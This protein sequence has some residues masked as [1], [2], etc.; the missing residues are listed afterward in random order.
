MVGVGAG[1]SLS[2]KKLNPKAI[3]EAVTESEVTVGIQGARVSLLDSELGD[4]EPW[5]PS[6]V[7]VGTVLASFGDDEMLSMVVDVVV[8]SLVGG[9]VDCP[10]TMLEGLAEDAKIG[11]QPDVGKLDCIEEGPADIFVADKIVD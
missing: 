6:V 7:W 9:V 2:V 1:A 4:A 5:T 8:V 11:E 3:P 10:V